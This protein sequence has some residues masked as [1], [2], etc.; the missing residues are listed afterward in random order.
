MVTKTGKSSNTT[1]GFIHNRMFSMRTLKNSK[2]F[3]DCYLISQ[4]GSDV[5]SKPGDSGS[6]VFLVKPDGT[7][8]PLGIL[9]GGLKNGQKVVCKIDKLI[10][11]LGL[12]I[13]RFVEPSVSTENV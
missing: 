7:H 12:K 5:F 3:Y 6:G 13:V 8:K 11:T 9:I 4:K 1:E 10:N 2:I